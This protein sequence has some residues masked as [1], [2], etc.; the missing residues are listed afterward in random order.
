MSGEA[1]E[2]LEYLRMELADI[3]AQQPGKGF[4]AEFSVL[5][6]ERLRQVQEE[7][8]R[9][10]ADPAAYEA[11]VAKHREWAGKLLDEACALLCL[12]S[13]IASF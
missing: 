5:R 4:E 9:L 10:E 8:S 7:I 2:R 13:P 12:E 6:S 1:S 3:E 11:D